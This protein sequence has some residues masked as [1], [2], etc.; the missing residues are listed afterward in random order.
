M[1]L[2]TMQELAIEMQ[3]VARG[4]IPVPTDAAEPSMELTNKLQSFL[5]RSEE[6]RQALCDGRLSDDST[7]IADYEKWRARSDILDEMAAIDQ[8]LG[9]I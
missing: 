3:A 2:C 6:G 7:L 8:E 9:L 1:K 5:M 4:E